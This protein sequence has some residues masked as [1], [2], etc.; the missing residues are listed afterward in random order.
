MKLS[1]Q[2]EWG[3]EEREVGAGERDRGEREIREII[4]KLDKQSECS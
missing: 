1:D 2:K 3:G 4:P